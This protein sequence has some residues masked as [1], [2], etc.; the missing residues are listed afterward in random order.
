M[1]TELVKLFL[2]RLRELHDQ[3]QKEFEIERRELKEKLKHAE[4][5]SGKVRGYSTI[6]GPEEFCLHTSRMKKEENEDSESHEVSLD[7]MYGHEGAEHAIKYMPVASQ[8]FAIGD[9][10][11]EPTQVSDDGAELT[12]PQVPDVEAM[13]FDFDQLDIPDQEVAAS[14][15]G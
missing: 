7:D 4:T 3:M 6:N 11:Q 12:C 2:Q 14:P 8:E 5:M 13:V 15:D 10:A 9:A 1:G